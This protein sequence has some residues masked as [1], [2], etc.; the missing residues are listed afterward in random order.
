MSRGVVRIVARALVP[1]R[2]GAGAALVVSGAAAPPDGVGGEGRIGWL[3]VLLFFG[4]F[5][6]WAAFVRLDAAAYAG[7]TVAVAG[8]RQ[9]VQ[10]QQ[11]GIVAALHVREGQRVAQGQVLI[12]LTGSETRAL[13]RS[14]NAQA[15]ARCRR[16]GRG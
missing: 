13:E 16:S 14:L 4:L 10:H 6:G 1:R 12:E 15:I 7:G 2:A 8:N 11:G 5:L 3:L 9:A